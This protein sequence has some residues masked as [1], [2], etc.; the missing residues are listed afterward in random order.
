MIRVSSSKP[1]CHAVARFGQ[2]GSV[3]RSTG[4]L[5]SVSLTIRKQSSREAVQTP[6]TSTTPRSTTS[7]ADSGSSSTVQD[8]FSRRPSSS[9][10]SS[11]GLATFHDA[12]SS[13][14]RRQ[15]QAAIVG[16]CPVCA[17]TT[18]RHSDF[19]SKRRLDFN[20]S[21]AYRSNAALLS[22]ESA[23]TLFQPGQ[24]QRP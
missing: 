22:D 13:L 5:G 24:F 10:S 15:L 8:I 12:R 18:T 17:S 16:S 2:P 7:T 21:S 11:V 14:L 19:S 1:H 4:L 20:C 9:S 6:S 23:S 3:W